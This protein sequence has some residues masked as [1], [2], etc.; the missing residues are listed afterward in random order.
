M[1]PH[2][3]L[4]YRIPLVIVVGS[5]FYLATLPGEAAVDLFGWD[6]LDHAMAFMVLA[7]LLD[8]SFPAR[9]LGFRKV[10]VLM[11]YGLL[12]EVVQY[13]LPTRTFSLLDLL[14]DGFGI[15]AYL[16]SR[17]MLKGVPFLRWRW[18]E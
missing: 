13:T 5:V 10:S 7:G 11:G 3:L 16:S 15:V 1:P 18:A 4:V 14:A 2:S 6:K 9:P 8:F 12:I 17:S